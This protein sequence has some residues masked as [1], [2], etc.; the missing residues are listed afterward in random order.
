ML[1]GT[2]SGR[3]PD[4]A[5]R[6]HRPRTRQRSRL[7]LL[8]LAASL[9][10]LGL[11]ALPSLAFAQVLS[12]SC[13]PTTGPTEVGVA[14]SATCT[15]SDGIAPYSWSIS[16]G[17]L[18][19]GLTLTPSVD[20]TTA[21]ISGTPTD[22]GSYSYTVQVTDSTPVIP[23]TASQDYSGTIAA[24]PTAAITTPVSGATYAE[25]QSVNSNFTCTEGAGGPG[26]NTCLNQNNQPSGT[27]IDT[28]T[29][30]P[31]TYTV[32]ATSGDGLT[33]TASVTYNVA[34]PPSV[35]VTSPVGG[36][37]Y[38][39]GQKVLAAYTCA[40]GTGGPGLSSCTA[41]TADGA[42]VDTAT[43]GPHTYTIAATSSDGQVTTDTTYYTVVRPSNKVVAHYKAYANGNL[44]IT[45]K[46]PG[47]G[48]VD[49]LESA[50]NS[51][52][53]HSAAALQ[54][55]PGRFAFGRAH[56][57]VNRAGTLQII[58]R[59]SRLGRRLINH[60]AYPVTLRVW[61]AYT[62]TGGLQGNVHFSGIH[63]P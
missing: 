41:T 17:S 34:A 59:P 45:L 11:A 1:H 32:T 49:I 43:P 23:M 33:G 58:V 35:V 39:V 55:A 27:P 15:A 38:T 24:P 52:L 47:P 50:S 57:V 62:P 18:P 8:L 48:V 13:T 29:P 16:A 7:R 26:I 5:G 2:L 25:G 4:D 10:V 19:N 3:D 56:V 14:Y 60:P 21:T 9:S 46:V 53:A 20:T 40:E 36:S 30:G 54:P 37:I 6:V 51:N 12:V 28:S 61:I 42:R 63:L 31:H 44:R 22:T